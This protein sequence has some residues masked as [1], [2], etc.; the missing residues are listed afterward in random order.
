MRLPGAILCRIHRPWVSRSSAIQPSPDAPLR[1][2]AS[3][4]VNGKTSTTGN[5]G[6]ATRRQSTN[7]GV[8]LLQ[9]WPASPMQR[10]VGSVSFREPIGVSSG[11]MS[12]VFVAGFREMCS[13]PR[14]RT[15]VDGLV[16][17]K[18]VRSVAYSPL[19]GVGPEA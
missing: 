15:K 16:A 19:P 3:A 18:P 9:E 13:A 14:R 7:G 12:T 17:W 1:N 2:A 6:A 4:A 5:D 11:A 8:I 10:L